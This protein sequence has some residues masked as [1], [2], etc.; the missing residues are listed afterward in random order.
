MLLIVWRS[1]YAHMQRY[2]LLVLYTHWS[3]QLLLKSLLYGREQLCSEHWICI[4]EYIIW[5]ITC[6]SK[7]A[8]F[9]LVQSFNFRSKSFSWFSFGSMSL[10]FICISLVGPKNSRG[11]VPDDTFL[12]NS[13]SLW[14]AWLHVCPGGSSLR[15]RYN[16]ELPKTAW[17]S[18]KTTCFLSTRKWATNA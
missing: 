7:L 5:C 17:C 1:P 8:M 18:H 13:V 12:V 10:S 11:T 2:L 15:I 6:C 16:W 4:W 14:T 9:I 3:V